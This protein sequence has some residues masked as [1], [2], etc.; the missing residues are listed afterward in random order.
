[1]KMHAS[2][3]LGHWADKVMSSWETLKVESSNPQFAQNGSSLVRF[4]LGAEA[5]PGTYKHTWAWA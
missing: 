4:L 2:F 1:M 3:S 5:E